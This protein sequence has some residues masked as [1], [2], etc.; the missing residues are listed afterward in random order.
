MA[1]KQKKE[2]NKLSIHKIWIPILIGLAF[3]AYLMNKNLNGYSFSKS[4]SGAYAWVD[5]NV[6]KLVS[7]NELIEFD[8]A[9]HLGLERYDLIKNA[10]ILAA[11]QF[12][13]SMLIFLFLGF[14]LVVLRDVGYMWRLRILS[15]KSLS[16]ISCFRSIMLWE[17][18]SAVTP[19][20]VGGSG[21]AIFILNKEGLKLGTSTAV[22]MITALMDELF[23][24]L[25]VPLVI[26]I[27]GVD[28]LF[29]VQLEKAIF[30]ITLN[31]EA[32]F[33]VGY[34]FLVLLTIF[35]LFAILFFPST[36]R[37]VLFR[38]FSLPLLRRWRMKVGKMGNDLVL[39]SKKMKGKPISFW[40]KSFLATILSWTSRYWV[41]NFLILAFGPLNEHFMVYARQLVMWVIMLIS[42][43]PGGAGIAEIAF[44]GFLS[45]FTPLGYAA[46]LA[47][48]WRL[49]TYYP[50][51]IM[52]AIILPNWL[53]RKS[54]PAN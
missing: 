25:M 28:N 27:V 22:V 32:L 52:G 5:S 10:D 20:V 12:S 26:A 31:T 30:G 48:L 17:F 44:T 2:S 14:V 40:L 54:K 15:D 6:D 7:K 36:L 21:V 1:K 23:Y 3:T 9:L 18:S 47:I 38:I 41:V 4:D 13:W 46:V 49:F 34:G 42:P 24:V 35:I 51:L 43:T 33:W 8:A 45:E 37:N 53:R 16:W 50:Y 29:P 19:S 39:T 11:T